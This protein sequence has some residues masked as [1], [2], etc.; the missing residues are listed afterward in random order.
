MHFETILLIA[1]ASIISML[2]YTWYIL[3]QEERQEIKE[4]S[5]MLAATNEDRHRE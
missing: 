5:K 3:W 4:I 1:L 2:G